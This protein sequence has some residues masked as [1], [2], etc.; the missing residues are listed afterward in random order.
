[1]CSLSMTGPGR[2]CCRGAPKPS[3]LCPEGENMSALEIGVHE[4]RQGG[5]T[6]CWNWSE[7]GHVLAELGDE[8]Y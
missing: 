7:A 8:M 1:V 5:I 2:G 6:C 4:F 3:A